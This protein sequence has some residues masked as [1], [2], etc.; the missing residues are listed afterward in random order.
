MDQDLTIPGPRTKAALAL[1]ERHR[2]RGAQSFPQPR[3]RSMPART[4]AP[5]S[6]RNTTAPRLLASKISDV[7][8]QLGLTMRTIRLYEE[9]G[10]IACG[11][12]AKNARVLDDVAKTRLRTIVDLKQ[13]GLTISEIS[14]FLGRDGV[15]AAQLRDRLEARLSTLDQ[16]RAAV[17]AYLAR[18]PAS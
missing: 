4:A 8:Q 3:P 6:L 14:Q 16:Q 15:R 12:G 10:L 17:S 18:L 2:R 11:R 5:A 13:M 1:L 9:M 7:S